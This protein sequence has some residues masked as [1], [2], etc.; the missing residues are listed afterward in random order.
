MKTSKLLW[1]V[2]LSSATIL[3]ACGGG[4]SSPVGT[5]GT[6]EGTSPFNPGPSGPV[7]ASLDVISSA[8]QLG[9]TSSSKVTVTVTALDSGKRA[10]ADVDV[11]VAVAD[12]SD[13]VVTQA[14]TKTDAQGKVM[15]IAGIS[16]AR[17]EIVWDP[18]WNQGM[19]S[20]VGRMQLGMV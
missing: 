17:V 1:A 19:I 5:S 3:S 2:V 6:S 11:I 13:A 8:S 10:V 14:Q 9:N 7:A 16:D 15:G 4:G 18:P 20:E 12:G